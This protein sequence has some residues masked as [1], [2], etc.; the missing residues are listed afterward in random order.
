MTT[1]PSISSAQGSNVEDTGRTARA[2]VAGGQRAAR[3]ATPERPH[4][5]TPQSTDQ[6]ERDRAA[7]VYRAAPPE[8]RRIPE[9][10]YR[11]ARDVPPSN[12]EGPA[13]PPADTHSAAIARLLEPLTKACTT[14]Q[15]IQ[16]EPLPRFRESLEAL[17]RFAANT[18][19]AGKTALKTTLANMPNPCAHHREKD[20]ELLEEMAGRAAQGED[21]LQVLSEIAESSLNLSN[22]KIRVDGEAEPPECHFTSTLL[23]FAEAAYDYGPLGRTLLLEGARACFAGPSQER[24]AA[25]LQAAMFALPNPPESGEPLAFTVDIWNALRE[26]GIDV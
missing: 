10:I 9:I 26:R 25:K 19:A 6:A 11:V 15:A 1:I 21:P 4:E 13:F 20:V 16:W 3:A 5:A 18:D 2:A 12:Q 8:R 17:S 22:F 14:G 24:R 7:Q 23:P